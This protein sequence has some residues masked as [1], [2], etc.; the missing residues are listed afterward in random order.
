LS[1]Q[2]ICIPDYIVLVDN[3]IAT[4][5]RNDPYCFAGS[6]MSLSS[7]EPQSR[8]TSNQLE[9][10]VTLGN[11]AGGGIFMGLGYWLQEGGIGHPSTASMPASARRVHTN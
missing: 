4:I 10:F 7:C 9:I 5:F 11:L 2:A 1:R 3:P 8:E 6:R